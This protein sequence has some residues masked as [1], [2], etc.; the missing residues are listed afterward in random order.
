MKTIKMK[1]CGTCFRFCEDWKDAEAKG[2]QKVCY[3]TY[4][5]YHIKP[6]K[7]IKVH[8]IGVG[9]PEDDEASARHPACN[10]HLYR[11][12]WNLRVWWRDRFKEKVDHLWRKYVRI[13]IGRRRKPVALAWKD[14]FDGIRDKIIP[15]GEPECP[16]CGNMPYST[17][18]CEICGQRFVKGG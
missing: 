8:C 2:M 13:P 9:C 18:Q 11:W 15:N 6:R 3:H 14:Y 16:H 12:R 7:G 17:E 5:E 4:G 1:T 10:Y